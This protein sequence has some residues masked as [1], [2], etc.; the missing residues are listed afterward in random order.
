MGEAET[1]ALL[2]LSDI[3]KRRGLGRAEADQLAEAALRSFVERVKE[4]SGPIQFE[5]GHGAQDA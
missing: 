3:A 2:A 4:A 5:G 1:R